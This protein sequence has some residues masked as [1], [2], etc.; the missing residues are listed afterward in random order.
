MPPT[1]EGKN[2]SRNS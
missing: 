1:A 2:N